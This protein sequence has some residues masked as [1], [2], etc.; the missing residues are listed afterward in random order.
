MSSKIYRI[1]SYQHF[2]ERIK[3]SLFICHCA[4]VYSAEEAFDFFNKYSQ[5]DATHNCWAYKLIDSYRFNDDGEPGGTAGRPMLQAIEGKNL[6]NVASLVIRYYGGIK[7]GTGGLMRAYGGVTA[8]CLDL[9][10]L[11]EVVS[12]KKIICK[13]PFSDIAIVKSKFTQGISVVEEN[14][15][16][17]GVIWQLEVEENLVSNLGQTVINLTKGKGVW[18]FPEIKK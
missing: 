5:S 14:F 13:V 10:T 6:I 2:E 7:L 16:N 3:N 8:K 12:T 1:Q 17:E 15:T 11:I 4:P 9:A 18:E